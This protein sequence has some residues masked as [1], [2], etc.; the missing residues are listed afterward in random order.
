MSITAEDLKRRK[1][2]CIKVDALELGGDGHVFIRRLSLKARED[3][4]RWA[5]CAQEQGI[6]EAMLKFGGWRGYLLVR[7][8]CDEDG[9]LLFDNPEDG[10]VLL[11]A[12]D[13]MAM[14]R[15]YDEAIAYS[16]L[17]AEAVEELEG[18]SESGPSDDSP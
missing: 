8:L 16:G 4:E 2:E 6:G 7:T 10:L 5:Q 13:A 9:V 12:C 1:V 17:N 18:N 15:L 14:D 3:W 11:N